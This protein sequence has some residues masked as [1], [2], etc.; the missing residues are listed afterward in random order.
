LDFLTK[1]PA[2][3]FTELMSDDFL[4]VMNEM[5]VFKTIE[6]Y[7]GH[8]DTL[9]PLLD[10]EDPANDE[11][12]VALLTE[13]E[14]KAREEAKAKKLEEEKKVREN[15]DAKEADALKALDDLGKI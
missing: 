10:E 6:A 1:L 12:V 14:K 7:L 4:D 5:Q 11:V 3:V 2:E 15:A 13:S 8:R 9:R